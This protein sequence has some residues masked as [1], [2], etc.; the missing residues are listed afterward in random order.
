M[1]RLGE[2]AGL[3]A[4]C[5]V[6]DDECDRKQNFLD[7][8]NRHEE[9]FVDMSIYD[10]ENLGMEGNKQTGKE[11]SS[12]ARGGPISSNEQSNI[13]NNKEGQ[14]TLREEARPP[15]GASGRPER[16]NLER[17]ELIPL[18]SNDA[19]AVGGYEK[20]KTVTFNATPFA[21]PD[22]DGNHNKIQ[23]NDRTLSAI[24][25]FRN[26]LDSTN[27][28]RQ[29]WGTS[30][31]WPSR[32]RQT[33]EN[34]SHFELQSRVAANFEPPSGETP[35]FK[36]PSGETSNFEPPLGETAKESNVAELDDRRLNILG[37]VKPT[38]DSTRLTNT[39]ASASSP[40]IAGDAYG[41]RRG[42]TTYRPIGEWSSRSQ[43]R[44]RATQES[45]SR[46]RKIDSD[47]RV[48]HRLR[49]KCR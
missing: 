26:L 30:D 31:A 17:S 38:M 44:S 7:K 43:T 32:N 18:C 6:W 29:K 24:G 33:L 21:N 36:P 46:D 16:N 10:M 27:P 15:Q 3:D 42:D 8:N 4:E 19:G 34:T 40:S 45:H 13:G 23:H 14:E 20:P 35:N 11:I 48:K 1:N 25:S 22:S 5:R 2:I 41:T 9:S 47:E 37:S 49:E 39:L 28:Q 12:P